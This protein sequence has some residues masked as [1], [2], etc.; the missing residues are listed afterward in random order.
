MAARPGCSRLLVDSGTLGFAAVGTLFA[1]MLVRAQSRDVLLPVVL[2][3]LTVPVLHRRG[4]GHGRDLRAESPI[5][6]LPQNVAG[7]AGIL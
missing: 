4:A 5:S 7:D 6:C 2:Y 1:A 3:P